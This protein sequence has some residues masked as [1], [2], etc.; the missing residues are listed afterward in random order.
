ME[1]EKTPIT[2]TLY[3]LVLP[4]G[5]QHS[6]NQIHYVQ[7]SAPMMD[8][9]RD[10]TPSQ[11]VS[12]PTLSAL[13]E[14]NTK[15][16]EEIKTQFREPAKTVQKAPTPQAARDYTY[17]EDS[18]RQ[19]EVARNEDSRRIAES[20]IVR[21]TGLLGIFSHEMG[22]DLKIDLSHNITVQQFKAYYEKDISA[23]SVCKQYKVSALDL[24]KCFFASHLTQ[25]MNWDDLI[26]LRLRG[27]DFFQEGVKSD[28]MDYAEAFGKKWTDLASHFNINLDLLVSKE[29]VTL[30]MIKN[31]FDNGEITTED[32]NNLQ[33][34]AV[35]LQKLNCSPSDINKIF[36]IHSIEML[37]I[38]TKSNDAQVDTLIEE[39]GWKIGNW[40]NYFKGDSIKSTPKKTTNTK[41]PSNKSTK[42]MSKKDY[43]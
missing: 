35:A 28:F 34:T 13:Q 20:T 25:L 12:F 17:V 9:Q 7:P 24:M 21:K 10:I 31:Q 37:K 8:E 33:Y 1:L 27:D 19:S 23:V 11:T 16:E 39:S 18:R 15:L 41:P 38:K 40:F 42:S 4:P 36:G 2:G 14:N 3:N 32:I 26:K 29:V 30:P 6:N 22:K 5:E 43:Q